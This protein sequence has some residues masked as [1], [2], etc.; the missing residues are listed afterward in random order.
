MKLL[1]PEEKKLDGCKDK[2]G[3]EQ[4]KIIVTT[5]TIAWDI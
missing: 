5:T 3:R 1:P 2:N 4:A